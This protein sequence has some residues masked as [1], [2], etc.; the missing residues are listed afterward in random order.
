MDGSQTSSRAGS[1][2]GSTD[3][4]TRQEGHALLAPLRP[5]NSGSAA[6]MR[7]C[8]FV[9]ELSYTWSNVSLSPADVLH[10]ARVLARE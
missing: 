9:N 4:T 2:V 1:Q 6:K 10:R 3:E 8:I 7:W 5:S